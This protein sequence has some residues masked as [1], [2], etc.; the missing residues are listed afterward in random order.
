MQTAVFLLH[1]AAGQHRLPPRMKYNRQVAAQT[2]ARKLSTAY[3]RGSLLLS[4][5]RSWLARANG[6]AVQAD[7]WCNEVYTVLSSSMPYTSLL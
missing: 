6:L 4:A 1:A 5:E 7:S 2:Q 3:L